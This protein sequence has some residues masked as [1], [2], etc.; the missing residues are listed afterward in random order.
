MKTRWR[1]GNAVRLLENGEE[2]YPRA[3]ETI[4]NARRSVI[5]ETFILFEDPVGE[6]LRRA[7]IE[8]ADAGALVDLLVDGYGSPSFS[9]EFLGS[10]V[11]AGVR[12]HV[13]DP[14]RRLLG[15]RTNL[16]RRLHRK[17]VIVD[18]RVAY[19]GGINFSEDHLADS[20]ADAKQDYAVEVTGPVVAD[21]LRSSRALLS[22]KPENDPPPGDAAADGDACVAFIERDNRSHRHDIERHY[23]E[24]I[25]NARKRI[26]IANAYFL[27]GYRLLRELRNAARRGVSVRLIMQGQPDMPSVAAGTRSLYRYL[28]PAGVEVF[29]YCARPFHGK[30]ALVDDEWVTI[31][32]SN[33]DPLSLWLNLEANIVARDRAL[34]KAL[35]EKLQGLA[36]GQCRPVGDEA[37]SAGR[38]FRPLLGVVLFHFLRYFPRFARSFSAGEASI[39]RVSRNSRELAEDY[40]MPGSVAESPEAARRD[41]PAQ[42]ADQDTAPTTAVETD[43]HRQGQHA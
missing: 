25:R 31:G 30:V 9:A 32:S 5:V 34:N 7:L 26:V 35:H 38:W 4:R 21:I 24:A 10:L 40:P 27:P 42:E 14:R 22:K 41:E 43:R 29:E 11:E 36:D 18:E 39:L 20:G 16:F 2:Y 15:F 33:L 28:L 17:I 23:R 8:A 6:Q 12:V 37:M 3:F 13:F 19:V 1:E